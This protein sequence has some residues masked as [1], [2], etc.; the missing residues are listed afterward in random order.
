MLQNINHNFNS[1]GLDSSSED[2]KINLDSILDS[3]GNMEYITKIKPLLKGGSIRSNSISSSVSRREDVQLLKEDYRKIKNLIDDIIHC[4]NVLDNYEPED[5]NHYSQYGYDYFHYDYTEEESY[6]EFELRERSLRDDLEYYFG[7]YLGSIL[8]F[9]EGIGK[10]IAKA[11]FKLLGIKNSLFNNLKIKLS[12]YS[13][14]MR[15]MIRKNN[16][17]YD[18]FPISSDNHYQYN[19]A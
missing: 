14:K 2:C 17:I 16:I 15:Y 7:S 6:R 11:K 3:N 13:S 19:L 18:V 5:E 12:Y 1:Y 8:H 4:Q 10:I 9:F